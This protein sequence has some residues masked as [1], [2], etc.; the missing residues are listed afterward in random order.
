MLFIIG[1]CVILFVQGASAH[2][3][4]YTN[5]PQNLLHNEKCSPKTYSFRYKVS[6]YCNEA[7]INFD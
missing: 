5:T 6:S 7:M 3:I 2:H 1:K 4:L